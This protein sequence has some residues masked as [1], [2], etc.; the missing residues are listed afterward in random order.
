M[1][2]CL[3]ENENRLPSVTTK[4]L[5]L[6]LFITA[7]SG[8]EVNARQLLQATPFGASS[9][10]SSGPRIRF[11]T[12]LYDFGR[13]AAGT[14]VKYT[15][16]FTNGGDQVLEVKNVQ[17][18]CGCAKAGEWSKQVEPGKIGTIPVQ[19]NSAGLDGPV[20]KTVTVTCNDQTTP[21]IIL[22]L[23]GTIWKRVV[24]TP[25]L[26]VF[27]VTAGSQS[28]SR[29]VRIIN[30][31]EEPLSISAPESDNRAFS[32]EVK[33]NQP[34]KEFRLEVI[35]MPPLSP[36]RVQGKI[37]LKTSSTDV[38]VL[39]VTAFADVQPIV[40]VAP[41]HLSLPPGPLAA[42]RALSVVIRNNS[43]D[44]IKLSDAAINA[45]DVTVDLME[46]QPGRSFRATLT[47]PPGFEIPQG[48]QVE[49]TFKSSHP[50]CRLVKVP[51]TQA[52]RSAAPLAPSPAATL[53]PQPSSQ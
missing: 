49:F 16:V 42:P 6:A 26:V 35:T 41:A 19:F 52:A 36:G 13:E 29:V 37:T 24:V 44:P 14:L 30:N 39:T 1:K 12:P 3:V 34:G 15:Y 17:A 45:K 8:T 25:P 53:A 20:S 10:N 22:H 9:T 32:A 48:Q 11:A 4:T 2:E 47:F 23:K 5:V 18:S 38:P 33:T 51:V 46:A 40:V 50:L 7:L 21:T 28:A 31:M 27:N 43:A